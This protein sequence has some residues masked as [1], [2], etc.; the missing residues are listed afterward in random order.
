LEVDAGIWAA[1]WSAE[2]LMECSFRAQRAYKMARFE[3]GLTCFGPD[4]HPKRLNFLDVCG[5][6]VLVVLLIYPLLP[7]SV[8]K[9]ALSLMRSIRGWN[10]CALRAWFWFSIVQTERA[11]GL[12]MCYAK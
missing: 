3:S 4:Y 11:R 12:G 5:T 1:K 10:G 6:G 8:S 9:R 2:L 7:K